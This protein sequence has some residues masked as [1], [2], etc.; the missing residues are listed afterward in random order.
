[1]LLASDTLAK[2]VLHSDPLSLLM[3]VMEGHVL[4]AS[5]RFNQSRAKKELERGVQ[6][7]K[8]CG[9]GRALVSM[10]IADAVDTVG[11]GA[12][13]IGVALL[14][15]WAIMLLGLCRMGSQR[16]HQL[17]DADHASNQ[18]SFKD[19]CRPRIIALFNEADE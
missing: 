12:V 15:K 2:L 11:A 1:L 10:C 6:A 9:P 14:R 13:A 4:S 5:N 3:Q 7:L 8:T 18:D 19:V 16:L 17:I